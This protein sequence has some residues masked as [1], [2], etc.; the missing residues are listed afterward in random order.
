MVLSSQTFLQTVKQC[1]GSLAPLDELTESVYNKQTVF[2]KHLKFNS[3]Q[4][5]LVTNHVNDQCHCTF[6]CLTLKSV[7]NMLSLVIC[8]LSYLE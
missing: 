5:I 7:N 1:L 3:L 4:Q 2:I 8:K 6:Y